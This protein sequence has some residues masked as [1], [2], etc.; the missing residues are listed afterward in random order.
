MERRKQKLVEEHA[1][2]VVLLINYACERL[3]KCSKYYFDLRF[4]WWMF[5][6][7][8]WFRSNVIACAFRKKYS[9]RLY[10]WLCCSRLFA[11]TFG[12]SVVAVDMLNLL[13]LIA[14]HFS[15]T[16]KRDKKIYVEHEC[17]RIF[18]SVPRFP[19]WQHV[20]PFKTI[21]HSYLSSDEEFFCH[22]LLCVCVL[23]VYALLIYEPNFDMNEGRNYW[24]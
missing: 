11:C 21:S 18:Y 15:Q 14:C 17:R 12:T 23:C 13:Y 6:K 10:P 2:V 5:L 22:Y 16:L 20:I 4:N 24:A 9:Y 8:E 19:N 7:V 3:K 1:I